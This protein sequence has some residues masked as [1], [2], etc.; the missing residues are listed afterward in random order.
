[1]PPDPDPDPDPESV[2]RPP[3]AQKHLSSTDRFSVPSSWI[4]ATKDVLKSQGDDL[5]KSLYG[6]M[7]K[8]RFR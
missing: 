2:R 7:M 4:V 6:F 3:G 5:E 1:M 8:F